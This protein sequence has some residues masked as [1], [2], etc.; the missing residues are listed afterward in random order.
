MLNLALFE[1]ALAWAVNHHGETRLAQIRVAFEQRTG[2]I[3]TTM[4]DYESRIAHFFECYLCSLHPPDAAA[5]VAAF[6]AANALAADERAQLAAWLRSYRSLF[7]VERVDSDTGLV[8]DLIG[9]ARL[10][11][12]PTGADRELRPGDRFDG[13]VAPLGARLFLTPSRVFHPHQSDASLSALLS[14]ARVQG[15]LDAQLLD[16]LLRMRA[17]FL[18]FESIRVEH[19]YRFDALE[20]ASF[21]APW[22]ARDRDRRRDA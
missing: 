6:A 10:R 21:S 5:P 22:A 8:H 16:P 17:R 1:R 9:G 11:F 13:R 20:E 3:R 19:V 4:A 15:I 14:E 7:E 2:E 12:S 18:A